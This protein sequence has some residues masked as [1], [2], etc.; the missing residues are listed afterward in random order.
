MTSQSGKNL[1]AYFLSDLGK[2]FEA[3]LASEINDLKGA[4]QASKDTLAHVQQEL[5][6]ER[7]HR[8]AM[9]KS[10]AQSLAEA[11]QQRLLQ[12]VARIEEK[13]RLASHF[14]E[15]AFTT[16]TA[17]RAEGTIEV[18]YLRDMLTGVSSKTDELHLEQVRLHAKVGGLEE[19]ASKTRDALEHTARQLTETG[20]ALSKRIDAVIETIKRTSAEIFDLNNTFSEKFETTADLVTQNAEG[21]HRLYSDLLQRVDDSFDLAKR[22]AIEIDD[23]D[24][25]V[26]SQIEVAPKML[27]RMNGIRAEILSELQYS[28]HSAEIAVTELIQREINALKDSLQTTASSREHYIRHSRQETVQDN[29]VERPIIEHDEPVD[30][31]TDL[32]TIKISISQDLAAAHDHFERNFIVALTEAHLKVV[33]MLEAA[34]QAQ[35]SASPA[36]TRNVEA[37]VNWLANHGE[38]ALTDDLKGDFEIAASEWSDDVF[39]E[40][41]YFWLLGRSAEPVGLDHHLSSMRR[42]TSRAK[43]LFNLASSQEALTR[44]QQLASLKHDESDFLHQAYTLFLGRGMDGAGQSHYAGVLTRRGDRA[45]VRVMRDIAHSQEAYLNRTPHASAWR[46]VTKANSF[47]TRYRRAWLR[48]RLGGRAAERH[49][50]QVGRLS[51]L[52]AEAKR[53]SANIHSRI[54]ETYAELV[55]LLSSIKAAEH[56]HLSG[57]LSASQGA[58]LLLSGGNMSALAEPSPVSMATLIPGEA[59]PIP[60]PHAPIADLLRDT[61]ADKQVSQIASAI[62]A[63]LQ[64]LGL[65]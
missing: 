8:T 37:C 26:S 19:T 10:D 31:S 13:A 22:N 55:K 34:M 7:A 51:M 28:Q 23:L 25:V 29:E 61:S 49:V 48:I 57:E 6:Q 60:E 52:E 59:V 14:S 3:R 27:E 18:R 5:S 39:A 47:F 16:A 58:K 12:D 11:N 38:S 9:Q 42:G 17:A 56:G 46:F 53:A 45:R 2:T 41:G 15:Q 4:L 33:A 35:L 63:E 65:N 64:K 62:R 21:A 43:F 36:A 50:W 54:D 24:A 30:K 1:D 44:L 20:G 40:A 32:Q